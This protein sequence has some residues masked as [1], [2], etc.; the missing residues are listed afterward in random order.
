M[1]MKKATL[2][3]V[4]VSMLALVVALGMMAQPMAKRVTKQNAEPLKTFEQYAERFSEMKKKCNS[5][6]TAKDLKRNA[7]IN[8]SAENPESWEVLVEEDFSLMKKGTDEKPDTVTFPGQ[9]SGFLPNSLFHTPGW[10]GLGCYQAGGSIALNYPGFGGVLNT[11]LMNMQGRLRVQMRVKSI[12]NK[13]LFFANIAAGGYDFPFDPSTGEPQKNFYNLKPEDGWQDIEFYF[14]NSYASSDCFLQINAVTYSTGGLVI[15]YVNVSRE[16]GF[17]GTPEGLGA[18]GFVTD[19]F[20]AYWDKTYGADKYHVNL[21]EKKSLSTDNY[22][23]EESFENASVEDGNVVGLAE[24]WTAATTGAGLTDDALDGNKAFVL[25]G[26][27]DYVQF[28]AT[29][30]EILYGS[31][32]VKKVKADEE[33]QGL[34]YIDVTTEGKTDTW[35]IETSTIPQTEWLTISTD[36]LGDEFKKGFASTI[37]IYMESFGE[38]G[39]EIA[40]DKFDVETTPLTETTCVAENIVVADTCIVFKDLDMHNLYSFQVQSV[41]DDGRTSEFSSPF[42]AYGVAAPVVKEA[43]EIDRRGAYTANWEPAVNATNYDLYSYEIYTVNEDTENYAVFEENFDKCTEGTVENPVSVFND[44]RIALDEYTD[45]LGWI[46]CGTLVSNGMVGCIE[47]FSGYMDLTS[48]EIRLDRNDGKFKVTFDFVTFDDN[49]AVVVQCGDYMHV[50]MADKAGAHSETLEMTGG[51]ANTQLKFY[52]YNGT[53]FLLDR[54]AVMQDVK[55]GED[56]YNLLEK[57]SVD[58]DDSS[59][60]ISGLQQKSGYKFGYSLVSYYD[61]YGVV[62]T[63]DFSGTQVVDLMSTNINDIEAEGETDG[64][65]TE[66]YDLSGRKI[67]SPSVNGVYIIKKG[68]NV[69]KV[70]F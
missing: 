53:A 29:A 59:V 11:P 23:T 31:F 45:N 39:E 58:G 25:A 51:K 2:T 7:G 17:L 24:G 63:S 18:N 3:R 30:S 20:N 68:N 26:S 60:R 19:G 9:I 47:N 38:V 8:Q 43:T 35:A 34:L 4:F 33:S 70:L 41:A 22:K 44:D 15:D 50:V 10:Y 48:P 55:A 64:Q 56:I 16:K 66:I 13:M 36:E 62:Y 21:Y 61:Y 67:T 42:F 32:N 54:V 65:M 57:K 28:E 46:G 37:K 40:I 52:S 1:I 12:D 5:V 27:D 69:K 14:E 6:I 49:S